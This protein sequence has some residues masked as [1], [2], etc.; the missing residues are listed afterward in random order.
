VRRL[1]ALLMLCV[2]PVMAQDALPLWMVLDVVADVSYDYL[3]LND[4][5]SYAN[6][7]TCTSTNI[8][9]YD[10]TTKWSGDFNGSTDE[11]EVADHSSLDLSTAL[12]IV[13]RVRPHTYADSYV[14]DKFY[15]LEGVAGRAWFMRGG[16]G[17]EWTINLGNASGAGLQVD[18]TS[19]GYGGANNTETMIAITWTKTDGPA[20]FYK[21]GGT[22]VSSSGSGTETIYNNS[23]E[24]YLGRSYSGGAHYNGDT[25][26]L[27]IWGRV[28]TTNEL[29]TLAAAGYSASESTV[30][31]TE[32]RAFYTMQPEEE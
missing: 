11:I 12:T 4:F 22:L 20:Y 23:Q 25:Y 2:L 9:S 19:S 27:G 8:L 29:N 15:D 7:G 10:E 32:L 1:I 16:A 6:D 21:D 13:A 18:A 28:L 14:V 17:G 3:T 31:D 30:S 26:W 5:S 24:V